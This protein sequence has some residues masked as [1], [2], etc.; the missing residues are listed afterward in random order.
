[1]CISLWASSPENLSLEVYERQKCRPACTSVQSDQRLCHSLIG[2]YNISTCYKRNF[3]FLA[4]LCSWAGWFESRYYGNPEDR[5]SRDEAHLMMWLKCIICM[6]IRASI[7]DL[8]TY[9]TGRGVCADKPEQLRA[10]SSEPS[11]IIYTQNE[12]SVRLR[13]SLAG[14][15]SKACAQKYPKMCVLT[16]I[17]SVA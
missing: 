2:K 3:N 16:Q 17:L 8:H 10:V 14:Y 1:M 11:L 7:R 5:F 13:S 9:Y 6:H 12:S 15:V 4:S